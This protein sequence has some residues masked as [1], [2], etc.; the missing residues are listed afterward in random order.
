MSAARSR[1]LSERKGRGHPR[2]RLW[3]PCGEAYESD[4]EAGRMGAGV[5]LDDESLG[6]LSFYGNQLNSGGGHGR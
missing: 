2:M 4:W 1:R 3:P 6:D 5:R